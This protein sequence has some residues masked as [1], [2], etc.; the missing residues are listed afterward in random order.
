MFNLKHEA[1]V[2][3][4]CAKVGHDATILSPNTHDVQIL[5]NQM[6][7]INRLV[8]DRDACGVI[9]GA[10]E[11]ALLSQHFG[12]AKIAQANAETPQLEK[13]PMSLYGGS[14]LCRGPCKQPGE[15]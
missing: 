15:S 12:E 4:A 6:P 14:P 7:S 9:F 11:D 5:V 2:R 3:F 10:H 1:F 13:K 8:K